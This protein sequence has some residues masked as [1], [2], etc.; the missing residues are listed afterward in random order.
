MWDLGWSHI[1]SLLEVWDG[2]SCIGCNHGHRVRRRD[3]ELL[4]KD[5][6]PVSVAVRGSPEGWG[7]IFPH[8]VYEVVGI[9]QVGV[10]M[11]STKVFQGCAIPALQ[12]WAVSSAVCRSRIHKGQCSERECN[13]RQSR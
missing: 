6:V 4:A 10:R 11:T 13:S 1:Q 2:V 8:Q 3:E 5:H 9:G 7:V 12:D